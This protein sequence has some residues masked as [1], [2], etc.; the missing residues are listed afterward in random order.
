MQERFGQATWRL[1][2][3][4]VVAALVVS[5]SS[6]GCAHFSPRDFAG[7]RIANYFAAHR[8]LAPSIVDAIERGHVIVGM[9]YDQVQVVVG[10][11]LRK[12]AFA[13]SV[14][15]DVWLYPGYRFHQDRWHGGSLYRI[16]F[17]AGRVALV[18]P[19]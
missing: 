18:E 9:D 12:K 7:V 11:P 15:I 13:G 16:V 3:L 5:I 14:A 17:I 6:A 4:P 2:S 1:S 19:I 8:E 10:E